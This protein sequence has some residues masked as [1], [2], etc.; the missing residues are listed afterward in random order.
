MGKKYVPSEEELQRILSRYAETH[1]YS[2]VSRE[3]GISAQI[4]SRLVKESESKNDGQWVYVYEGSAPMEGDTKMT[5]NVF[6][7]Q[8]LQLQRKC[9]DVQD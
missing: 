4:V 6:Y 1:N 8:L 5:K 2:A 3:F 9:R 7:G